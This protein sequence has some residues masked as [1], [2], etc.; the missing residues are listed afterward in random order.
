MSKDNFEK[1]QYI[2]LYHKHFWNGFFGELQSEH[3]SFEIPLTYMTYSYQR[4]I[5]ETNV[6]YY[7]Q[8]I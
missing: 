1:A 2:K 5:H 8:N 6:D 3:D 7:K 4:G